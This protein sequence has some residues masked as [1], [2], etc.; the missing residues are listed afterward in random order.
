MKLLPESIFPDL[1]S[2]S[3]SAQNVSSHTL[4]LH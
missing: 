3:V 2:C 1:W 4:C